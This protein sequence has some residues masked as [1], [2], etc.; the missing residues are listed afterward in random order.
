MSSAFVREGD[1]QSLQDISPS[2]NALI[3][4][5]TQENNGVRVYEL[6]NY[7]DDLGRQIHEMSNGLRYFKD[8]NSKWQTII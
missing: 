6:R 5:L 4:F 1:E 7:I 2:L 8:A 3:R